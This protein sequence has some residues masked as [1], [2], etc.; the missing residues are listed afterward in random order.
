MFIILLFI[1]SADTK[2][3]FEVIPFDTMAECRAAEMGQ[4]SGH[5]SRCVVANE[6]T[7]TALETIIHAQ[8]KDGE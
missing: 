6:Q 7:I 8:A 1:L 3:S 5:N 2:Y 4:Y